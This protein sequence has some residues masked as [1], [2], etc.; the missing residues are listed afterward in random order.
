MSEQDSISLFKSGMGKFARQDFSGASGD[1]GKALEIDPAF[2][3]AH[4]SMAHC[5]EKLGER[6]LAEAAYARLVDRY[7]F[8]AQA[9]RMRKERGEPETKNPIPPIP[10]L[11]NQPWRKR[12]PFARKNQPVPKQKPEKDPSEETLTVVP[13]E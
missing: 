2:A 9:E 11:K 8:S 12:P 3:D 6:L 13:L 10:F 5:H 4:Q 1:F 7:P